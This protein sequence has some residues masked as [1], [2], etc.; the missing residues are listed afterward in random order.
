MCKF[1]DI[2]AFLLKIWHLEACCYLCLCG[3]MRGIVMGWRLWGRSNHRLIFMWHI[4]CTSQLRVHEKPR[5][6]LPCSQEN[7][8]FYSE[9]WVFSSAGRAPRLHRGCHRF[10]PGR[11]HRLPRYRT[12]PGFLFTL[13]GLPTRAV[14]P[15]EYPDACPGAFLQEWEEQSIRV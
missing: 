11:T 15:R 12:V 4:T 8:G 1:P 5:I 3:F 13:S 10:D 6:V 7:K 9:N 14:F 2:R